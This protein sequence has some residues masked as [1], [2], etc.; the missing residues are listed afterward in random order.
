MWGKG[1]IPFYSCPP[2][3]RDGASV[4][5][6]VRPKVNYCA[7]AQPTQPNDMLMLSGKTR[8]LR[9]LGVFFSFF[10]IFFGFALIFFGSFFFLAV[11]LCVGARSSR[12]KIFFFFLC[13]FWVFCFCGVTFFSFWFLVGFFGLCFFLRSSFFLRLKFVRLKFVRWN[14]RHDR[15]NY[16]NL[17]GKC[18]DCPPLFQIF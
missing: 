11:S 12:K 14:P 5:P 6:W 1:A 10:F 17:S 8:L 2:W 7:P 3:G 16:S 4:L 15:I 13:A 9:W 18:E